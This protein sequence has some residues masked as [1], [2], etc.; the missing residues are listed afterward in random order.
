MLQAKLSLSGNYWSDEFP[1]DAVGNAGRISCKDENGNEHSVALEISMCQS[2]LTK[3]I[4]F[5]PF[6]M[7]HNESQHALEVREFGGQNWFAVAPQTVSD[8]ENHFFFPLIISV[9][10]GRIVGI[11]VG[12]SF[13][14]IDGN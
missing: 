3:V 4:T 10:N 9:D 5:L 14:V 11:C 7:L 12:V 6:Y 8:N 2:G 1:L 13:F